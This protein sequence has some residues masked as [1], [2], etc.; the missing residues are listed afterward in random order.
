MCKGFVNLEGAIIT[1]DSKSGKGNVFKVVVPNRTYYLNVD[2]PKDFAEW[3]E[4]F[5]FVAGPSPHCP[6]HTRPAWLGC[7]NICA[8]TPPHRLTGV[9]VGGRTEDGDDKDDSANGGAIVEVRNA[10]GARP[11]LVRGLRPPPAPP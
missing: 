8:P 10:S 11:H 7:A 5:E 4:A 1:D 9:P 3:C 6:T 2:D